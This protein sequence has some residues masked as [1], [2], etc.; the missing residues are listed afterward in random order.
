MMLPRIGERLAGYRLDA[1]LGRGGGGVVYRATHLRL[2][3]PVALK[4]LPTDLA[5]DPAFRRRF[6]NE[7]K[8]AASLVHPHII[9]VYD[10]GEADGRLY[11]VMRLV[12]GSDLSAIIAENGPLA[13]S[14]ACVLLEQ[15]AS[16]LTMMHSRGLVHRD[17]KPGNVLVCPSSGP[18][19]GEHAFVSDFGLVRAPEG[20]NLTG[21]LV[22][23]TLAYMAPERFRAGVRPDPAM[24]LYAL[25][26]MAYTCLSGSPPF[27]V[28][29]H[30]SLIAA[31]LYTSPR[32]LAAHDVRIPAAVDDVLARAL[33]KD[34]RDRHPSCAAFANELRTAFLPPAPQIGTTRW[35][36]PPVPGR[37]EPPRTRRFAVAAGAVL[38]AVAVIAGIVWFA[39]APAA[40][41][42]LARDIA[43]I[44]V[45]RDGDLYLTTLGDDRVQVVRADGR[46]RTIAGGNGE[47]FGGDGGPATEALLADPSGLALA[48]DGSVLIADSGN[49]RVRRV[50]PD[51]TISTVAG[52]GTIGSD[53]DGGQAVVAQ[54]DSPGDLTIDAAGALLI[55]DTGNRRVRA[56]DREGRIRTVAGTGESGNDGDGG[57]AVAARLASVSGIAADPVMGFSVVDGASGVVRRVAA[58]GTISRIAGGGTERSEGRSPLETKLSPAAVAV[59]PDG[60]V[61]ITEAETDRVLR[62]EAAPTGGPVL[63]TVLG[64]G[65][66]GYA[67]D[68][69]R[70][71]VS[72]TA[73]PLAI[74][75]GP[76]GTVYVAEVENGRV[77]TIDSAGVLGTAVGA[78][79][80]HPRDGEAAQSFL[81]S[82]SDLA[83]DAQG[84]VYVAEFDGH[85][86]RRIDPDGR[87][88]TVA[89]TGRA[90]FAGD[91]GPATE[92]QLNAPISVAVDRDGSLLVLDRSN[93]RLRRISPDGVI[94]TIA[95][96]GVNRFLTIDAPLST[97]SIGDLQDIVV[98]PDGSIYLA[99]ADAERV[100]RV[101]PDGIVR[102]LAGT[103]TTGSTGA[104]GPATAA[105]L[106]RPNSLLL[107]ADGSVVVTTTGDGTVHRIDPAGI[108][109]TVAGTGV[110]GST[111]DGG[112]ARAA[113]L[114]GPYGLA[115]DAAG[116]LLVADSSAHVIRRIAPDATISRFAG[117]GSTARGGDGGPATAAR[118]GSPNGMVLL[119]DGSLL[120]A[121]FRNDR[122]L[123]VA[124]GVVTTI[125]GH[126]SDY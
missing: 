95:G 59:G 45:S 109:T 30:E 120:A 56:V 77:R 97:S 48:A 112:P 98:G 83:V 11:L 67:P 38:L 74:A 47:G 104:D 126:G 92:A 17:V 31:H 113:Q 84:R 94:S 6:D 116:G 50:G 7:A 66:P 73:R 102:V 53:G 19:V 55:A 89:G 15:V 82:P 28:T 107:Q 91:G 42:P 122:I 106:N 114:D 29:S 24:D 121:D 90:G 8:V 87:I 44:A 61:R 117:N 75:V 81:R 49:N 12:E 64:V 34:P 10:A 26:C 93:F 123:R 72:A 96:D 16:A 119:A 108:I 20:T 27:D 25:G 76:T 100:Y 103:G 124:G 125:A 1:V 57:P 2:D 85:R 41:S 80:T 62:I 78:G 18:D 5:D 101:G 99:G 22:V 54:L 3:A 21:E 46:I 39:R 105:T 14:R 65:A 63:R 33:A 40:A 68:G 115:P 110:R 111:G 71:V 86:I 70:A 36:P 35:R 52:T 51:G 32:R 13:P 43:A 23:G 69:A 79:P 37:T 9:P 58:D 118:I 88:T 60:V 4:V